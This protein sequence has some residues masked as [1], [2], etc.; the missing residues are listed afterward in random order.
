LLLTACSHVPEVSDT[1]PRPTHETI[2]LTPAATLAAEL[3]NSVPSYTGIR[4]GPDRKVTVAVAAPQ[5]FE[6][7]RG[8]A[9]R[10]W[11]ALFPGELLQLVLVQS[12]M[13]P[14]ELTRAMDKMT[15][16]LTLAKTVY[17]APDGSCGCVVIGITDA[18]ADADV[19]AFA[20]SHGVPSTAVRTIVTKPIVRHVNLDSSIRPT[21]GGIR[22]KSSAG[23]CTLGLPVYHN[24]LGAKGFLT[25]SHCTEG[26]QGGS[27]NTWFSQ[28]GGAWFWGDKIG[29]EKSD[30]YLFDSHAD[31]H[32]ETGRQCRKTDASF[33]RYDYG[34]LGFVGRIVR[35]SKRCTEAGERCS[36]DMSSGSD[37]IRITSLAGGG[38][39]AG[40]VTQM[41]VVEGDT[42]DKVG[43]TTGWTS[44]TVVEI[45][46]RARVENDDGS[47]SG[48][49]LLDQVIVAATSDHGDSGAPAFVYDP[50]TNTASF[51]GIL[52]G[53]SEDKFIFSPVSSIALELGSMEFHE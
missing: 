47:D 17:L 4:V 22:I 35:P 37:D 28:P 31:P 6:V 13:T 33:Q 24:G 20:A 19:R 7:V 48:I 9:V 43:R 49:T 3:R 50:G 23:T 16:I 25:A 32:C 26:A 53:G 40:C 1:W 51:A 2:A 34:T 12:V 45:C 52:W 38:T 27:Q 5:D 11:G 8:I 46:A 44:G 36:T 14:V 39:P 30:P 18:T 10:V 15:D 29:E 42:V 41:P 21:K